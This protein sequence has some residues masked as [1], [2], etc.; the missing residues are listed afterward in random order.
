MARSPSVISCFFMKYFAALLVSALLCA[1]ASVRADSTVVFNEIMFH[2]Q[3][4]EAQLEWVELYNQMA[5]DMD[6][7]NWY[8]TN[9]ISYKFAEGTVVPGGGFLVVA[10]SPATLIAAMGATNVVGPFTGRLANGNETLELRNNNNRLMDSVSYGV[11]GEWPVATDGSGVS[12][13]KLDANGGSALPRSWGTSAQV[14]GTPGSANF[15]ISRASTTSKT[16]VPINQTWK[17]DQSGADLGTAWIQPNYADA[18]WPSGQGLLAYETCGCLPDQNCA[19]L[20]EPIRTTLRTNT[21]V[22]TFYFRTTFN[23]TN[24]P[25]QVTLSLKHV[26]DDGMILYLNGVEISRIGMPTGPVTFS[27]FATRGI[28]DGAYEG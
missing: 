19:C 22:T 2:P 12:L 11:D 6:I 23:F 10:V 16:I 5:V 1:T 27:T 3:T 4:N 18:G 26:I 21:A 7:S 17:Y 25:S 15:P 13:T 8:L 9:G 24:D 14:G 28:T 20:P